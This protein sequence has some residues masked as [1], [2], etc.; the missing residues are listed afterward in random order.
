MRD[1]TRPVRL[2][3]EGGT[4][5]VSADDRLWLSRAVQAEGPPQL[6][7][8]VALV[9]GFCWARSQ[10]HYRGSLMA[11]VRSYAQPVNPLW[12]VG[13]SAYALAQAG[14]I[15]EAQRKEGAL[16]AH[17]RETKH[18]RRTDFTAGV[19]LAVDAALSVP[20]TTDVT[21]YA[22]PEVDAR[23]KGY[24]PRGM[25]LRGQNRFWTRAPG[26]TGYRV[27]WTPPDDEDVA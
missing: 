1:E 8:A 11:W 18:S 16:R 9:N 17:L 19:L 3:F 25:V 12:Y 15:D 2:I 5:Q 26:W 7:V 20:C 24:Q 27:D 21:D 10:R 4:Y 22:A 23:A 6:G 13:G 14:K